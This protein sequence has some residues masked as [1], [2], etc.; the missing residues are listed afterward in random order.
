MSR[1]R[2]TRKILDASI[3][4]LTFF[5]PPLASVTK[6]FTATALACRAPLIVAP[7]MNGKMWDHPATQ[8]NVSRLSARGA[9]VLDVGGGMGLLSFAAVQ[10]GAARAV[11]VEELVPAGLRCIRAGKHIHLDKPAGESLESCK[12]LHSATVEVVTVSLIFFPIQRVPII[13]MRR[14][15]QEG[16]A[17]HNMP[18][19]LFVALVVFIVVTSSLNDECARKGDVSRSVIDSVPL[20]GGW[21]T[22]G[23]TAAVRRSAKGK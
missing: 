21:T 23:V 20:V 14:I 5:L 19:R 8:E 17:Q 18:I 2:P 4:L 15:R 3:A 16:P 22:A 6:G 10:R 13:I 9:R 7:A 12:E 1:F 11:L